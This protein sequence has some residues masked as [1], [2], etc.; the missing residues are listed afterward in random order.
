MATKIFSLSRTSG[1]L[2]LLAVAG[3][4]SLAGCSIGS[5]ST[6]AVNEVALFSIP[7]SRDLP[8]LPVLEGLETVAP[9]GYQVQSSGVSTVDQKKIDSTVRV[10]DAPG[11]KSTPKGCAPLTDLSQDKGIV[12]AAETAIFANSKQVIAITITDSDRPMR[13]ED[14]PTNR[15]ANGTFESHDLKGEFKEIAPIDIAG[16]QQV[17]RRTEIVDKGGEFTMA[18]EIYIGILSDSRTVVVNIL[19]IAKNRGSDLSVDSED[20]FD[21]FREAVKRALGE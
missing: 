13:P 17:S 16:V 6:P 4:V 2:A 9:S 15:C 14:I 5:S 7:E 19:P 21:L 10:S 3:V 11:F 20:A 1:K 18:S 8:A 12:G